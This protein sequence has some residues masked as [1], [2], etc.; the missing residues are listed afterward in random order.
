MSIG[1]HKSPPPPFCG[2]VNQ[3]FRSE[4]IKEGEAHLRGFACSYKRHGQRHISLTSV[5]FSVPDADPTLNLE[6]HSHPGQQ[7]SHTDEGGEFPT[8]KKIKN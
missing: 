8:R 2:F 5:S 6:H 1:L 7:I 3:T 4:M